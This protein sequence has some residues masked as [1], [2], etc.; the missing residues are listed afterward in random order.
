MHRSNPSPRQRAL[1]ILFL[2]LIAVNASHCVRQLPRPETPSHRQPLTIQL[3]LGDEGTPIRTLL[4]D[5]YIAG[6]LLAEMPLVD[7]DSA[8]A[9]RVA[10]LQAI[11][12]RTYALS[13]RDRHP[14]Q[15]FDL[16]ATTHCQ[17]YRPTETWPTDSASIAVD[18]TARTAG[19]VIT[20]EGR[21]IDALYHS[22]C[23]GH[24][25]DARLAWGNSTPPYLQGVNDSFCLRA[26]PTKWRFELDEP[27]LR[28]VLNGDTRTAVGS[29]LEQVDVLERDAAGRVFRVR[30]L[31]ER[32]SVVRGEELRSVL[33]AQFGTRSIR[34]TRFNVSHET[35]RFVFEGRGYGHGVG[36]CQ[37]GAIARAKVGHTPASI[38]AHYYSG[39]KVIRMT[40]SISAEPRARSFTPSSRSESWM[41]PF[42]TL[43]MKP[44]AYL[45][46]K[47][48]RP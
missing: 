14:N 18:A 46:S 3:R 10:E 31:G 38:I 48:I 17:V 23:G 43:Q 21:L 4:L 35:G 32:V 40:R 25:S 5:D 15:S 34:S 13:R 16:C 44:A 30:L 7:L 26:R 28:R 2:L 8:S 45:N 36:L 39:V 6:T 29:W 22:D 12:S 24:T 11:V 9:Q 20:H 41:N 27:S 37:R 42:K 33:A 47:R 1:H 19:L